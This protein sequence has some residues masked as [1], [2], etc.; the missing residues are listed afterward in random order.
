[1]TTPLTSITSD[2]HARLDQ[3]RAEGKR[4]A[5][6]PTMGA[7]HAGHL[8]LVKLARAHADV[9]V[10]YIFVNPKQFG[11][12]ED[13]GTY[14]RTLENDLK[15]LNE[16]G[17]DLCYA[18]K[19]EDVYPAGFAA[20]VKVQGVGD[21]LEGQFRPGFFTGVATVLAK[22]FLRIGPDVAVFGE[23]DYQ[24]LL[25][26]KKMVAD[27]EF[28]IRILGGP[29]LREA[30]GLA[31]SSR[32]AYLSAE[33]RKIAPALY[34]A[35]KRG[36][37]EKIPQE[38]LDSGFTKVDYVALRDAETLGPPTE[39]RPARLLAAAWIGKTRLIDN[40]AV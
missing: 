5:L 22:M 18:P 31:M 39:G 13:F 26:V 20:E 24:Q 32:N 27:L 11:A 33:E 21:T 30:D 3:W 25:V 28:P 6:V 29:T 14:P 19:V 36:E 40:I 17:A 2:L 7:L 38:L 9:V 34:A 4:I 23:K 1:M 10:A 8:S 37:V 16:V 12:N 35:L 15:L